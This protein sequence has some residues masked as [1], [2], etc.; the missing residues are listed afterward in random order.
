MKN[1]MHMMEQIEKQLKSQVEVIYR[2]LKDE[3]LFVGAKYNTVTSRLNGYTS[4]VNYYKTF[5]CN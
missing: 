5:I 2:F 4:D 3:Q 1:Q